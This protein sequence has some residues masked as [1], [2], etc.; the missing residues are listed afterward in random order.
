MPANVAMT[1]ARMNV[2]QSR[3]RARS[4]L[5]ID[6]VALAPAR[7]NDVGAELATESRHVHVD[8]VREYVGLFVVDVL[9][10]LRSRHHG[11]TRAGEELENRELARGQVDQRPRPPH[12]AAR[13]V[14]R[15]IPDLD[16]RY[17]IAVRPPDHRADARNQLGEGEWLRQVVVG[18]EI[19][20]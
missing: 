8:H 5:S 4:E 16:G 17:R 18:A 1:A 9:A 10:D 14:D 12:L 20:A 15:Q 19:Q 2:Y 13:R 7:A 11:S 6:D 3:S